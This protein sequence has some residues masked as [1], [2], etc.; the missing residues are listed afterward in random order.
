MG[1]RRYKDKDFIR[2]NE[3]FFFCVVGYIHPD[4]SVFS[5][6]RYVPN[7]SG[8][9]G[10]NSARYSRRM[11]SY[12]IPYLLKNIEMLK[13]DFPDY[14]YY[15]KV[16]NTQMSA[17]PHERIK[18][19]YRPE[20]RLEQM[21][22]LEKPDLLQIK[23]IK[24]AN[25]VSDK[26]GTPVSH[27]GVTGSL[28]IGIHRPEFSDIDLIVYGRDNS[29]KIKETILSLYEERRKDIGKLYGDS[30]NKWIKEK[31]RDHLLTF[32]EAKKLYDKKWNYGLFEGTNFSLHPV[33]LDS[34]ITENYGDKIF[35]PMYMTK[36]K[37]KVSDISDSIFLPHTYSVQ[38]VIIEE[39]SKL[40]DIREV[41]SYEGLYGGIFEIGEEIIV[42]GKLE[43]V[44]VKK[45]Q[46]V[47]YRILVGSLEGKGTEYIQTSKQ[48]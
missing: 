31:I 33:K 23:A 10:N 46:E 34:E 1:K 41:T 30:L 13:K 2:T 44:V 45:T 40:H 43:K 27:I 35:T 4:N 37:A 36:I 32:D 26:S 42:R 18:E 3:N 28:L 21:V 9:W 19:Y 12:T 6:I 20:E 22:K 47:Y 5:Y 48:K 39:G 38:K 15:S 25:L 8:K 16:F 14:V 17:V 29:L 24:L 7:S 11:P